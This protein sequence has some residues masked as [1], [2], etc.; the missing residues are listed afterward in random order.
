MEAWLVDRT[1]KED[2]R[3]L[4]HVPSHPMGWTAGKWREWYPDLLASTGSVVASVLTDDAG[5]KY[6]W[7]PGWWRQHQALLDALGSQTQRTALVVSGDLHALGAVRIERSDALDL[8]ANPVH[9]VLSGP[10]GVGDIGW[11]SRA[12]GVAA[13]L[14]EALDAEPLLALDERNGFTLLDFDRGAARVRIFGAP[15]DYVSP[16]GLTVTPAL[17]LELA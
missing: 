13:R 2:T 3:H 10:V 8:A 5:G 12:R 11:P 15:V 1:R 6:L 4:A 14:P 17:E 7:Q 16:A 9:A